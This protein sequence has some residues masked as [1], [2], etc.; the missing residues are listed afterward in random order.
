MH[1]IIGI[2]DNRILICSICAWTV[3]QILKLFVY[4][5]VEHRWDWRRIFGAGGM[6]SSHTSFVIALTIMTGAT[7]GFET[8]HFAIAFALMAIVMYDA[9]GV[10]RE[11]G[12]QAMVINR[13][14]RDLLINGKKISDEELKELVGH[15]PLEVFA[16]AL[17]GLIDRKSVV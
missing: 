16:G 15:S 6:P 1:S 17:L 5:L 9:M 11:A 10:R 4:W 14:I 12:T 2:L 3:A 13:I 8:V 7:Y